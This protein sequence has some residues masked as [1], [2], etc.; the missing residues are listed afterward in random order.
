MLRVA[1][2]WMSGYAAVIILVTVLVNL[3]TQLARTAYGL[4]LPSMR[5][6][7]GLSHFQEGSLITAVAV[8]LMVAS[9]IFGMLAARYGTRFIAGALTIA[10]GVAMVL[11]GTSTNFLFALAMSAMIGF[12]TGGCLTPV[13]GLL[14][15]WF[16]SRNRGHCGRAGCIRG[17]SELLNHR[18]P[19][20]LA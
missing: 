1:P 9:L 20:A 4:T 12:A 16:D 3:A 18:S 10:A 5:D 19:G 2:V 8:S 11:L 13:M 7:L 15:I 17:R 6:S 14:P